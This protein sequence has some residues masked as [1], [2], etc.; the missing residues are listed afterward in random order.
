MASS[1]LKLASALVSISEMTSA[2]G[3]PQKCLTPVNKEISG[4]ERGEQISI[5]D[6]VSQV[7]DENTHFFG[8][9]ACSEKTIVDEVE[10]LGRLISV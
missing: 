2:S 9:R 7:A 8:L 4:T 1:I 10:T 6:V 5:D 3:V